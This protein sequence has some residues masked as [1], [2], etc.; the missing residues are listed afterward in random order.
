MG[1]R[2]PAVPLRVGTTRYRRVRTSGGIAVGVEIIPRTAGDPVPLVFIPGWGQ[3][4]RAYAI[5]LQTF[6][7][8]GRHVYSLFRPAHGRPI[9]GPTDLPREEVRKAQTL[10]GA[11][12]RWQ[13]ARVDLVAHS[14]GALGAIIATALYP[15][16]VRNLILVDPGGLIVG[17]RWYRLA[18]RFAKM[19]VQCTREAATN[20][21]ERRALVWAVVNPTIYSLTHPGRAMAQVAALARWHSLELLRGLRG[22]DVGVVMITGVDNRVFPI[23]QAGPL[24]RDGVMLVD[25]FQAVRGGHAKLLGDARYADAVLNAID[26]L[27]ARRAAAHAGA[28]T[29]PAAV[30]PAPSSPCPVP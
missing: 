26:R 12:S 13:L 18:G 21:A 22:S 2:R 10:I 1:T 17:D 6:A 27:N 15:H 25:G 23:N 3:T 28:G 30:A 7:E 20:T 4:A 8:R 16:R 11:L 9:T 14:E 5:P 19:I 24:V 29:A